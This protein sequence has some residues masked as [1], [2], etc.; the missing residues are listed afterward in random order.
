MYKIGINVT[1]IIFR[2]GTFFVRK[3][4]TQNTNIP[5][6]ESPIK[7]SQGV[8]LDCGFSFSKYFPRE[9]YVGGG[10]SVILVSSGGWDMFLRQNSYKIKCKRPEKRWR[11]CRSWFELT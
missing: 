7:P 10:E 8:V 6:S 9:S 3:K 4:T 1:L 11:H 2:L 5:F